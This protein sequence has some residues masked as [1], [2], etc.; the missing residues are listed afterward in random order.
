MNSLTPQDIIEGG[1]K[2]ELNGAKSWLQHGYND[3][4]VVGIKR[5][6]NK[7]K[8]LGRSSGRL[9]HWTCFYKFLLMGNKMC[10]F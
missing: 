5:L 1:N 4:S 8:Y 9:G 7:Y 2:I 10:V 3:T 6:A